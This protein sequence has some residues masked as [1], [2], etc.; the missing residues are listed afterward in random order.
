MTSRRL[1]IQY[2]TVR[3][4]YFTLLEPPLAK[5]VFCFRFTAREQYFTSCESCSV[6]GRIVMLMRG[7]RWT[8]QSTHGSVCELSVHL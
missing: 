1:K 8:T 4:V 2:R 3:L 5:V 6:A 7:S